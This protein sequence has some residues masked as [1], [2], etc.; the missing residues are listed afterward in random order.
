[1][2]KLVLLIL[3][4]AISRQLVDEFKAWTPW[5][6]RK[7]ITVGACILPEAERAR[8]IEEW[9]SHID[10]VPGEISKILAA[11]GFIVAGFWI[12]YDSRDRIRIALKAWES[13]K[14][15]VVAY[16]F[17]ANL[18]IKL[19]VHRALVWIGLSR[20]QPTTPSEATQAMLVLLVLGF[21]IIFQKSISP[22]G[23]DEPSGA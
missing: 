22:A 1:M 14:N 6:T 12:R 7:L 18:L 21:F 8:L 20:E 10:E 13:A 9:A 15:Q 17:F 23:V 5:L 4:N 16:V 11:I 19:W 3:V 2:R